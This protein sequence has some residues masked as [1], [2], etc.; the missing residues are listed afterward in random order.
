[1]ASRKIKLWLTE[2]WKE[3]IRLSMLLN[4]LQ[5]HAL[6]KIELSQTQVRSIEVL[7][8]KV[9]PDLASSTSE[10]THKTSILDVLSEIS[11]RNQADTPAS[12]QPAVH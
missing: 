3:K 6:G 5:D 9:V 2:E 11:Q 1:M 7:L 8:R 4:R 10:I 12:E